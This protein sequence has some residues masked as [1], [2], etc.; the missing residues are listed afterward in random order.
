M[1]EVQ[2]GLWLTAPTDQHQLV[3]VAM[4]TRREHNVSQHCVYILHLE[5]ALHD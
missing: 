2:A 1:S 3:S 5:A 4:E